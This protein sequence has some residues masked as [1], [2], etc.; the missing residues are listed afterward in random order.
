M[1]KDIIKIKLREIEDV[2]IVKQNLPKSLNS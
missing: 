2:N 1:R